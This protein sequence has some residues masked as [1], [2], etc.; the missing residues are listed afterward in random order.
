MSATI[1]A[2]HDLTRANTLGLPC[3][4]ERFAAPDGDAPL[5]EVLQ[6]AAR[7]GWPLT[8]LGGGVT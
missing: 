5:R 7:R 6:L 4:A 3:M 2:E 1:L 8:L